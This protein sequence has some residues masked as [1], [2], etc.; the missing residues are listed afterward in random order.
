[1]SAGSK[2]LNAEK[3]ECDMHQGN[4]VGASVVGEL[5]RSKVKVKSLIIPVVCILE[6]FH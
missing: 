2:E 3:V 1:M 4:K 6:H 5:T